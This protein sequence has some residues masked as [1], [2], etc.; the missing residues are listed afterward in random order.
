MSEARTRTQRILVVED[1]ESLAEG[2]LENLLLDGYEAEIAADGDEGLRRIGEGGWDLVLLDVMLPGVD[3]FTICERTRAAG[4]QVPI[5]FLTAKGGED[6]RI[7]GLEVGG[8]DYLAKPF[9]LRELLLRITAILRR[10]SWYATPPDGSAKSSDIAFGGNRV[11]FKTYRGTSW[12]GSEQ[13]LTHKEALILKCLSDRTGEIVS[14]EDILE[15]VWGYEIFP[16]T[17]T[18]DNFIVR[19]RKRFEREPDAP[20]HFHTQRGVGY[21]FTID[22][23][24]RSEP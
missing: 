3:G 2:I 1:E 21:R 9:A 4:D 6:D 14:R 10:K 15:Q 24:T 23:E 22:E 7:R 13:Q 16:S 20:R 19:L 8:D 5:L 11:D 18:I 17:R 12:D